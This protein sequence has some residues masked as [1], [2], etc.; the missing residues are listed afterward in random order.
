MQS[1]IGYECKREPKGTLPNQATL[2]LP[3]E[4]KVDWQELL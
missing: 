2:R 3:S 1:H 4:G